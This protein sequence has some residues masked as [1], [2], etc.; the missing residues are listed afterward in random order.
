P[1]FDPL[2]NVN[3]RKIGLG[4]FEPRPDRVFRVVFS[5]E[6][7][8][9][10]GFALRPVNWPQTTRCY[11]RRK[12]HAD[13]RFAESWTPGEHGYLAPCYS[14]R[15]Q[16]AHWT[17]LNVRNSTKD[18]LTVMRIRKRPY[19]LDW[20]CLQFKSLKVHQSPFGLALF[21]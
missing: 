14:S 16:P 2:E 8:N 9:A 12:A 13:L 5:R 6:N 15:P 4:C 18:E 10:S 20:S 1:D 11:D 3:A 17:G 7:Q 21:N 19:G